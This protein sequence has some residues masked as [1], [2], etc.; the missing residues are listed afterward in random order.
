MKKHY[1]NL[2]V[3]YFFI[4]QA[5]S[6]SAID[7]DNFPSIVSIEINAHDGKHICAGILINM[8]YVLSA[9]NCVHGHPIEVH[10]FHIILF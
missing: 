3:C 2:L 1:V 9:A 5:S 8:L 7:A 10:H 6:E 4:F